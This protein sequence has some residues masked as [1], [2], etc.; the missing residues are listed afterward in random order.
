MSDY[1]ISTLLCEWYDSYKRELPWRQTRD[2]YLIWISEIILQQTR[3]QQGLGYYLRFVERFPDVQSLAQAPLEEVLK[4]WQG[5]GYYSRARNLHSAA[6]QIQSHYG[7]VFPSGYNDILALKGIGTYTAAAIASFAYDLPYAVLDGNV[8]RVLARLFGLETPIDTAIGKKE[9]QSLA[10]SL[11]DPFHAAKH[12]QAI[13]ELGALQCVPVSPDCSRCPLNPYC[14]AFENGSVGRLPVK[15]GK[16]K[17]RDRWFYY[18][19]IEENGHTWIHQRSE[20]DIWSHLYEFPLI[21]TDSEKDLHAVLSS[22]DFL[23]I[24]SGLTADVSSLMH[25]KHILSH[26]RIHAFFFRVHLDQK[27]APG[28]SFIRIPQ[29]RIEDYPVS[30]LT[31]LCLE[32]IE[33]RLSE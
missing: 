2:P 7:G 31:Q 20:G 13:M 4:Y 17:V 11:I 19:Y 18:F 23:Q 25:R 3:V 14:V 16:T 5:L 1:L 12:N 30:R 28:G 33:A 29:E 10:D 26:Q 21:E 8:Y 6:N 27:P 22:P 15:Q 9:F 24:T 32:K